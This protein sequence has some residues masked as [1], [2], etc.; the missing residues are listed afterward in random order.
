MVAAQVVPAAAPEDTALNGG[1]LQTQPATE[2][3]V[4]A[5][6]GGSPSAPA[7]AT[8][9]SMASSAGKLAEDE[10]ICLQTGSTYDTYFSPHAT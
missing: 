8:P 7:P 6:L 4:A 10:V 5:S 3:Q 2:S 9:T 1:E